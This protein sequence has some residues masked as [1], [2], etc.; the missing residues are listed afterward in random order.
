M[1]W[2]VDREG[3]LVLR[4]GVTGHRSNRLKPEFN[5]RLAIAAEAILSALAGQSGPERWLVSALA[6]GADLVIS[7]IGDRL[8]YRLD[9]ILPIPL[10]EYRLQL[11][12]GVRRRFDALLARKGLSLINALE[13]TDREEAYLAAGLRMLDRCTVLIAVWDGAPAR[14]PGGTGQIVELARARG[15]SVVWIDLAGQTF[16]ATGLAPWQ[17]LRLDAAMG[18]TILDDVRPNSGPFR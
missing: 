6:D 3:Q 9:V 15:M 10:Q 8:G 18:A 4:I 13:E 2:Q 11:P 12:H 7:E 17:D 14:G 16:L 5:G 1:E